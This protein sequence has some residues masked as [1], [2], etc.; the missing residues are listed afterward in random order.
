MR[1]S[2]EP[3]T[4]L[5]QVPEPL[6]QAVGRAHA[7]ARKRGLVSVPVPPPD[8][9]VPR[10]LLTPERPLQHQR[11]EAHG[12]GDEIRL[13][14]GCSVT[15]RARSPDAFAL[16]RCEREREQTS[17]VRPKTPAAVVA[18]RRAIDRV[19]LE[20]NEATWRGF[21]LS[22][23]ACAIQKESQCF[24][25]KV[26]VLVLY[27]LAVRAVASECAALWLQNPVQHPLVEVVLPRAPRV[28]RV[29]DHGQHDLH[30]L[31]LRVPQVEPPPQVAQH[32]WPRF[33]A[34]TP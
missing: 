34:R 27:V 25:Y 2:I 26:L 9:L 10:A 18:R 3:R 30:A 28:H 16:F 11:S 19:H 17:G 13:H 20:T 12:S 1:R 6:N 22:T 32:L 23:Y 8:L 29:R 5:R 33:E 24:L 4:H 31:L 21:Y 15:A 7:L 14:H